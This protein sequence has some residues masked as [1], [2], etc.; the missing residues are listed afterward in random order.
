MA[1]IISISVIAVFIITILILFF[2]YIVASIDQQE[3]FKKIK[4]KEKSSFCNAY[5]N[6]TKTVATYVKDAEVLSSAE[7]YLN[8]AGNYRGVL[9]TVDSPYAKFFEQTEEKEQEN[10]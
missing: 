1:L 6:K 5:G 7:C 9:I 2:K 8:T 3:D 10:G 4:E